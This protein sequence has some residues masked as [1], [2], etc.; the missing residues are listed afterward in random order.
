M[1]YT[2]ELNYSDPATTKE[3]NAWYETYLRQLVSLDGLDTAQRFQAAEKGTQFWEYLAL[4]TVPNLDVYDTDACRA[5]SGGAAMPAKR[6]TMRSPAAAMS[7]MGSPEC[8]RCPVPIGYCCVIDLPG[9]LFVPLKAGAG[10]Q[11]AGATKIDGQPER[12]AIALVDEV[13][14]HQ[15]NLTAIEGLSVYRPITTYYA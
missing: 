13:L 6:S 7:M 8:R 5:I 2:V 9:I 11:Q 3:W 12:R 10:D 15:Q 4:Y 1:I 14:V